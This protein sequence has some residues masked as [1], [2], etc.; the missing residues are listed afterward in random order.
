MNGME[1][2]NVMKADAALR[3]IPIIMQ[4]S[5]DKPEEISDG[6]KAGVFYYLL[7]PIKRRTLLSVVSSAVRKAKRHKTMR[8]E[9][10]SHRMSLGLIQLMKSQFKTL[11]EGESLAS[12]LASCFPDPD[13]AL[14]G[15]SEIMINAVEH[16]NL[17]ITYEEKTKLMEDHSW[18][19][20]VNRRF[21]QEDYK[22][23]QV[24]VIF[25]KRKDAYYLQVTD[26]GEG[27]KWK[28]FM[29]LSPSRASHNHGRGIAVA[30]MIVFDK[31]FY[32]KKGN[33]VTAVMNIPD[34]TAEAETDDY[35][36]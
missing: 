17:C 26:E 32:N 5:A 14:S 34:L 1:V 18:R 28:D 36:S 33:Q 30:N 29:E 11:D 24:S 16:G 27:F 13:R 6:I 4:T 9:M 15:I 20:E 31:L 19:E 8:C 3:D 21:E 10:L 22:N 2:V 25:E 35:W 7:K 12:F 23:K